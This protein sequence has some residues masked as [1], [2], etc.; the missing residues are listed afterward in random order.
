MEGK[1]SAKALQGT[2]YV[3]DAI[4]GE[5]GEAGVPDYNLVSNALKGKEEGA[6]VT[7]EGVSPLEHDIKVKLKRTDAVAPYYK[8]DFNAD[9]VVNNDDAT[10]LLYHAQ[11]SAE[12]AIPWWT[13]GDVDGN[14][15]VDMDDA[16][17]LGE[18]IANGDSSAFDVANVFEGVTLT[19]S[20]KNLLPYPY[21][22]TSG[23]RHGI[24]WTDNG[25]GT[26]TGVGTPTA[27]YTAG[28]VL[29]KDE[30]LFKDGYTYTLS[31]GGGFDCYVQYSDESGKDFFVNTF[32]WKNGYKLTGLYLQ[33]AKIQEYNGT[34][35]PQLEIGAT[36]TEY[37]PYKAPEIVPVGADGTAIVTGKEESITLYTDTAGV[38]IEAE[39]NRDINKAFAELLAKI[40]G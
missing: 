26:I 2:A 30:S 31:A 7:L 19:K 17:A 23:E 12:Y 21:L 37:E 14:G 38:T 1:V 9:G 40:G 11:N 28:F 39:Y 35:R 13:S 15:V 36:A 34:A 20:G 32:T 22:N 18:M 25:D 3:P 4:K 16:I 8:Y 5:K 10:Y 33:A 27:A 6:S 29:S 24:K